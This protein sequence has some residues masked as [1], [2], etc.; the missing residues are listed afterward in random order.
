MASTWIKMRT[1]LD[2][3]PRIIEIAASLG[4]TE[5]HVIGMLWKVWAWADEHTLDGNAL[6]VTNVT[7]D[8]FAGVT[9]FAD[10]LRNVGWLEGRDGALSFP[11][12]AEHNGQTAKKRAETNKRVSK[13]RNADSVTNV[14]PKA[15]PEREKRREENI[16][17][18]H[19]HADVS[20]KTHLEHP[21]FAVQWERW[22]KHQVE[23][24]KLVTPTST[25]AQLYKLA[26]FSVEEAI[27]IV[28]FSIGR[29]AKNLILNGD[30]KR[31][32]RD[33]PSSQRMGG[34]MVKRKTPTFEEVRN[35]HK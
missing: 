7:L 26:D 34:G 3:D 25:E 15:L 35:G 27:E 20:K 21:Q 2:S 30:H 23:Q 8:R 29:N 13:H 31:P 33:G 12:F 1:N 18:S 17:L 9:G 10:A 19:S 28:E 5:L 32:Q 11:R 6:R 16:T 4:V 22:C 14:T 24:G